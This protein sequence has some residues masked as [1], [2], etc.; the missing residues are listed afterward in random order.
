M[1]TDT[2]PVDISSLD[3]L[4]SVA[5][6]FKTLVKN[7]PLF[8]DA[9]AIAVR[10]QSTAMLLIYSLTD[11]DQRKN[12][13]SLFQFFTVQASAFT[14]VIAIIDSMGDFGALEAVKFDIP[15]PVK[16]AS[17]HRI[18]RKSEEMGLFQ[19][20]L[21]LEW[22]TSLLDN[23][24][25]NAGRIEAKMMEILQPVEFADTIDVLGNKS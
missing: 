13:V 6:G 11:D 15:D 19:M 14:M 2:P 8:A 10:G 18:V 3:I 17:D 22:H 24:R 5:Y 4:K 7:R 23:L 16:F 20:K 21:L 12:A 9:Q 1:K 25:D